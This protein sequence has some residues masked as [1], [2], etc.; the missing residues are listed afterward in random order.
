MNTSYRTET[1]CIVD[2]ITDFHIG[3]DS[4][5]GREV[6]FK[7]I[8]T[9]RKA[10]SAAG[11]SIRGAI[12]EENGNQH[13]MSRALAQ[14]RNSNRALCM[15]D[16]LRIDVPASAL[17]LFSRNDNG[18][19]QGHVF[20][21]PAQ[22]WLAPSGVVQILVSRAS[23]DRV[24]RSSVV[25]SSSSSS[26][27]KVDVIALH[28]S[29]TAMLHVRA[30][31]FDSQPCTLSVHLRGCADALGNV[32]RSHSS[33]V[34]LRSI[35]GNNSDYN[36]PS[37][38]RHVWPTQETTQANVDGSFSVVLQSLSFT[39]ASL[40]CT[41]AASSVRRVHDNETNATTCAL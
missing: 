21:T 14:A 30:V 9:V 4:P 20:F 19:D 15:G 33:A 2:T 18:W 37:A 29:A 13:G 1:L 6:D 28:D 12:F 26:C 22:A 10:L 41:V 25:S 23:G 32:G 35:H 31:N 36:T 3:G 40:T 17:Q 27:P 24:V 7:N 16:F 11:S 5:E 34:I 39:T 8:E 38:P